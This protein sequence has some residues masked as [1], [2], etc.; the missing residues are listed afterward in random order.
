[1]RPIV[2]M[3]AGVALAL[4]TLAGSERVCAQTGTY[5]CCAWFPDGKCMQWCQR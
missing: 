3:I 2:L 1:M 5:Y 4:V